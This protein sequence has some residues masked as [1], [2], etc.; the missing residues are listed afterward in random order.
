MNTVKIDFYK[1]EEMHDK[2]GSPPQGWVRQFYKC[3]I[4]IDYSADLDGNCVNL[5]F[6]NEEDSV[7]FT[8]RY[9]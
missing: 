3:D 7:W 5:M 9:L 4:Y 2:V 6:D 8:L 1:L